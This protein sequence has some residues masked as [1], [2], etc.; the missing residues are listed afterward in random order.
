M[1]AALLCL[2]LAGCATPVYLKPGASQEDYDADAGQCAA[3]AYSAGAGAAPRQVIF[4][5]C[6]RGKG[7]Q[8]QR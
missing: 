7:W 6:I 8:K 4:D 5:A 2:L 1:R 3:Q